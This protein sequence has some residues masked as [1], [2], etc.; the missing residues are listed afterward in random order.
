MN[1]ELVIN[2]TNFSQYFRDCRNTRPERGDVMARWMA[3][4]EFVDGQMKQDV[5]D[6]LINKDK[7]LS[8]TKI[9]QKLAHATYKDAVRVCKEICED[10]ESGM[11][12]EEVEAKSYPYDLEMFYYTKKEYVP[13]NDPHWTIIGIENLDEFLDIENK[14]ISIKSR[15]VEKTEVVNDN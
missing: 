15:I 10:L 11:T 6:L 5:I 13:F 3:R 7:A 9:M 8:A 2:E 4:A 1:D 12:V 14:R